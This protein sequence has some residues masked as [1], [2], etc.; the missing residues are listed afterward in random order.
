LRNTQSETAPLVIWMNGG[1]GANSESGIF[2]EHGP[3]RVKKTGLTNDDYL[4]TLSTDGS[5]VDIANV[6]YLDQ[7]VGVGFSYGTPII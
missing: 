3:F 7:P 5:W 2:I 1:P 4:L 6:V